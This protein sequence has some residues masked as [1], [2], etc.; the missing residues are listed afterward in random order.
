MTNET[1][2]VV[3]DQE[4]APAIKRARMQELV[5][6]DVSESELELLARGSPE[7]VMLNVAIA[8]ASFFAA[9]AIALFTTDIKETRVFCVF[10]VVT[11]V[12]G[13][14]SLVLGLLW[15]RSRRSTATVLK[16]IRERLVLESNQQEEATQGGS[17][18]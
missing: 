10:V 17:R 16:T 18:E 12:S 7:S 5:I 11:A 6:Y 4:L 1:T 9:F 15:W 14:G 2:K 13:L 8:C 3:P